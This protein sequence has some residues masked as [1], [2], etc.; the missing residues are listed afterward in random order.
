MT[1]TDAIDRTGDA[2]DLLAEE[3]LSATD[4]AGVDQLDTALFAAAH[5]SPHNA[6]RLLDM[7]EYCPVHHCDIQSCADDNYGGYSEFCF[8]VDAALNP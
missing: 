3:I 4:E 2:I 7:L 6:R 1:A 5:L 8:Y